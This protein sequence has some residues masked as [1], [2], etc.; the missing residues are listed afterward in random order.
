MSYLSSHL[1]MY[2]NSSMGVESSSTAINVESAFTITNKK[3]T[4][5]EEF[6]FSVIPSYVVSMLPHE[7]NISS[8]LY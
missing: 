8:Q 7:N 2:K 5:I 6:D 3:D 1:D 4:I